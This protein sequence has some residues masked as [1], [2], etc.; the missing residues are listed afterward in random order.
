[1]LK[2]NCKVNNIT[3]RAVNTQYALNRMFRRIN[4]ELIVTSKDKNIKSIEYGLISYTIYFHDGKSK[5][6]LYGSKGSIKII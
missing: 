4:Q 5:T 3:F 1:M 2:Y 6:F